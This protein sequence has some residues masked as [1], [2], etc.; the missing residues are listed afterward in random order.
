M[1]FLWIEDFDK[2]KGDKERLKGEWSGYFG[3]GE[4]ANKAARRMIKGVE[5]ITV[6]DHFVHR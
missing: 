1:R 4:P 6:M 5:N 3:L 2:G